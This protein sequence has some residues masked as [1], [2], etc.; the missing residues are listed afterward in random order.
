MSQRDS[1]LTAFQELIDEEFNF[2]LF[3]FNDLTDFNPTVVEYCLKGD[4]PLDTTVRRFGALTEILTSESD[5]N[6][7][8]IGIKSQSRR[9]EVFDYLSGTGILK[10]VKLLKLHNV[11]SGL[12]IT[13][14]LLTAAHFIRSNKTRDRH[15][16][17]YHL[18]DVSIVL[19]GF[20]YEYHPF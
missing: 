10:H 7:A 3:S 11:Q 16:N 4:D 6:F 20:N 17:S 2:E 19:K 13:L 14:Q 8:L 18:D 5:R 15:P 12:S 1:V 9:I